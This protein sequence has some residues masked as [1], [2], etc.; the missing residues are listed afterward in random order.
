MPKPQEA[1]PATPV[2]ERLKARHRAE[3]H[4]FPEPLSIRVHRAISWLGRAEAAGDDADVRFILMWIGFNA[5]YANTIN[6]EGRTR[7]AFRDF[8]AS[9]VALDAAQRIYRAVWQRFSN[10]IRVLLDN[11]YVFAPFWEHHNGRPGGGDWAARLDDDRATVKRALAHHDTPR[12]LAI[13]FDRLYV[14]RNQLVHGGATWNSGVNRA[15]LRDGNAVLGY[16]LPMF[17][18]IMMDNPTREWGPP[19]YPVIS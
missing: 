10:E 16:L 8:F 18:D 15:Q 3:R 6:S 2:F 1:P 11:Q 7:E 4:A 9:L 14:L 13:L 17:I 5:A 19:H 12:L